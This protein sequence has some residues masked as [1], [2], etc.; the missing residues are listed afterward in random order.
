MKRPPTNAPFTGFIDEGMEFKGEIVA[1]SP[2]RIDGKVKG[3]LLS[4]SSIIVGPK[5]VFDG[6]MEGTEISIS[7]TVIGKVVAKERIEIHSSGRVK[8]EIVTPVL[9]VEEGALFEGSSRMTPKKETI[10]SLPQQTA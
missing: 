9:V 7:G 8:A 4:S 2:L 6:E 1:R 5:A 3:K 10:K